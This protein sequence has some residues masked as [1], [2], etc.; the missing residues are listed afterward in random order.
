M[1]F[2]HASYAPKVTLTIKVNLGV[3]VGVRLSKHLINVLLGDRLP[4]KTK[5]IPKLLP[6]DKT[7]PVPAERNIQ[8]ME[9]ALLRLAN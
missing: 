8:Q 6:V 4:S 3:F 7:V 1:K 5:D 2:L 9:I